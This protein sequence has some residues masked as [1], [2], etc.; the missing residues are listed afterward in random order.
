MA[1]VF[2]DT[3]YFLALLDSSDPSHARAVARSRQKA[4]SFVTTDYVLVEL[5]DAFHRPGQREEYAVFQDS[6]RADSK[7][8]VLP[9]NPAL[10]AKGLNFFRRHRDK[11]W[12]L[13][14]CISFVVMKEHGIHEALTGDQHFEIRVDGEQLRD[15]RRRGKK[16]LEVV[17]NEQSRVA[18]V[19]L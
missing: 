2:A 12:Q 5:G 15:E 18:N 14:D 4:V 13:T 8:R 11:A 7:F 1:A 16:V 19:F 6:L 10:L 17:E 9:G 3:F